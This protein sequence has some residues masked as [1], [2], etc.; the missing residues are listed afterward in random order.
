M[1][2]DHAGL[3]LEIPLSLSHPSSSSSI[4]GW[5][6]DPQFKEDWIKHFQ[7][8]PTPT[9]SDEESLH[10]IADQFLTEIASIT[11]DLFPKRKPPSKRSFPWWNDDC[12]IAVN[13][14]KGYRGEER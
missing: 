13:N 3:L 9:P 11:D 7:S 4:T 2:S 14:L 10:S 12:K 5:K 8:L 1:G 6:I